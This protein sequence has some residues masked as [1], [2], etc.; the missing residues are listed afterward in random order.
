[1]KEKLMNNLGIKLLS[2][3][4]AAIIW[5]II[6]N[7]DDP[8]ITRPFSNIPIEFLNEDAISSLGKVYDV[9]EGNTVTVTVKGKRSVL[10][11]IKYT[12]LQVTADLTQMTPFNKIELVA[13]C[14]KFDYANLELTVKP[15]M[16]TINMEDK[17]IKQVKINV[18]QIGEAASGFSVGSV[19]TKPN[20]IEVSGAKSVVRKIA[21]ARVVVDVNNASASFK[22]EQLIPKVYDEEGK[23]IDS[24]RLKFSSA[25]ITVKVN[26]QRTKTVPIEVKTE[27]TASKGYTVM[28]TD[29]EPGQIEIAGEDGVLQD[30][31]VIPITINVNNAKK[32][33]EKEIDLKEY[34]PEGVSIVGNM[35]S[36]AVKVTIEKL[37]TKEI[38]FTAN[39]IEA[40]N[41]PDGMEFSYGNSN[42]IYKVKVMGLEDIVNK[43][44]V[45]ELGAY[46]DLNNLEKGKHV[47]TVGFKESDS[48]EIVSAPKV[49]VMLL[50]SDDENNSS[51]NQPVAPEE[52]NKPETNP[53][54]SKIDSTDKTDSDENQNNSEDEPD[55]GDGE[56]EER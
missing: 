29:F 47:I 32:D 4:L 52:T 46:I 1:M 7:I 24:S 22:E 35:T 53:D 48:F 37:I 16:L 39:D 21:E 43:L 5:I 51:D 26:I 44:T 14:P 56:S 15:K 41:I 49:S 18:E 45:S 11:K 10:D 9:E 27:G 2:I 6:I 30:I 3:P 25:S 23:E 54:D 50:S 19:E 55:S 36:I 17:E 20:L 28:K 8:A 33:I 38:E 34:L 13:S 31:S 42:K 12:D 40:K